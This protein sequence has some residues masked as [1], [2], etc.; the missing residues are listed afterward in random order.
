[1]KT[2]NLQKVNE[3]VAATL[4]ETMGEIIIYYQYEID[5]NNKTPQMVNFT[6]QLQG[7]NN[8]SGSYSKGGGFSLNGQ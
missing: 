1:M 5:N 4:M 8:L 6:T 7:G 3:R 2:K